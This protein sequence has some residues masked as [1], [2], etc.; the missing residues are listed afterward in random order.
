M[1]M[2]EDFIDI[3]VSGTFKGALTKV[4]D[5]TLAYNANMLKNCSTSL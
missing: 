3:I 5:S 2:L 4:L 1:C